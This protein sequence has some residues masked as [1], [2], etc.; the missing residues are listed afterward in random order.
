VLALAGDCESFEKHKDLVASLIATTRRTFESEKRYALLV[1]ISQSILQ[2]LLVGSNAVVRV[3]LSACTPLS[4]QASPAAAFAYCHGRHIRAGKSATPDVTLAS[5][6]A[7]IIQ[8]EVAEDLRQ[9]ITAMC[10]AEDP[11]TSTSS[12]VHE[13]CV[14]YATTA[15]ESALPSLHKTFLALGRVIAQQGEEIAGNS[16]LLGTVSS[17]GI[18]SLLRLS[19]YAPTQG[20]QFSLLHMQASLRPFLASLAETSEDDV[21]L[22][23][24]AEETVDRTSRMTRS[25]T[26]VWASG[27]PNVRVVITGVS[28]ALPGRD[29]EVF[30]PGVDNIQRILNGENFISAVPDR[31]KDAMLERNVV[32]QR[33]SKDGTVEC[34]PVSAYKDTINVCASLG[35][36]NLGVYGISESIVSTMDRA[37]QVAVA[38]GLEALQDAGL[39]AGIRGT[40]ASAWELPEHMRDS[41]GVVYATSFPALDT[42]VAEVARFFE[43][44][45]VS[46]AQTQIL[47]AELKRRL[48]ERSGELSAESK[49]ALQHL[50]QA[51]SGAAEGEAVGTEPYAFDRKFLFRVLVLGNAQLA[52][53]IKARGPNMQTNAACAG[54][55]DIFMPLPVAI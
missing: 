18:A 7:I 50:E 37:V 29:G 9:I 14:I 40:G 20:D 25:E 13:K 4:A 52:Q 47:V 45:T 10:A 36:I 6:G 11:V 35:R 28:A 51:A 30:T 32:T 53:I 43:S 38:A 12:A 44:K 55:S 39:V 17:T 15:E 54:R 1:D 19:F 16:A 5:T 27:K 31:V 23:L 2:V 46:T 41:T 26:K 33:R 8:H 3:D 22:A 21:G 49:E 42:A 24:D 34:V 48:Q